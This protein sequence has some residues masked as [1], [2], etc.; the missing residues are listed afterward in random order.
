[1]LAPETLIETWDVPVYVLVL[2]QPF[3]NGSLLYPPA[4]FTPDCDDARQSVRDLDAL[5]PQLLVTG[6]G[7][8]MSGINMQRALHDLAT[9][10]DRVA[11]PH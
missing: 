11:R 8:A 6:H 5:E 3:L 2:E 9:H 4:Y 7:R 1:M 10:F